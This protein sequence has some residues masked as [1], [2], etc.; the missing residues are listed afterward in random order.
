MSRAEL[1]CTRS[2]HEPDDQQKAPRRRQGGTFSSAGREAE[3]VPLHRNHGSEGPAAA[4]ERSIAKLG[5]GLG[6][7]TR[8]ATQATFGAACEACAALGL[9]IN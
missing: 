8:L 4:L 9:N 7:R 5:Q 3:A 6:S 2:S 1:F